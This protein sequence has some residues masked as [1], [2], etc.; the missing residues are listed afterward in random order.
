MRA[1]DP[2]VAVARA[3]RRLGRHPGAS[4][5]GRSVRPGLAVGAALVAVAGLSAA[6]TTGVVVPASPPP[7]TVA[8]PQGSQVGTGTVPVTCAVPFLGNMTFI[9]KGTGAVGTV[10][11]PGQQ[12]YL[13]DVTGDLEVPGY[14]FTLASIVGAKTVNASVTTLDIDASGATPSVLNAAA[15]PIQVDGI[16]VVAGESQIV[17]APTSGTLT[18]GPFTAPQSG[19]LSLSI[20]AVSVTITLITASGGTTFIPLTV[21]CQAPSPPIVLVGF[22]VDPNAPSSPPVEIA[23]VDAPPFN[24]PVGNVE[25]SLNVPLSCTVSG[26]GSAQLDGTITGEL[27]AVLPTGLPYTIQSATGSLGIPA[28]VVSQL[29]QAY[30]TATSA[31]GSISTLD[32]DATNSTPSVLNVASTPIDVPSQPLA[33]GQGL[34]IDLP[35]SGTL[36]VGPFTAGSVG[37]TTLTWGQSAGTLTLQSASGAT[38]ATADVSC[39]APAGPV[40]ILYE[41]VTPG[42]VPTITAVSPDSGPVTGGTSVTITGTGF[43]GAQGVSVGDGQASFVVNSSTQ[44]TATIP[45]GLAPGAAAITVLGTEGP[46]Q[47]SSVA[48]FTYTSSSS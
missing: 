39:Q 4:G 24:V 46:S 31:S 45:P 1:M 18:L 37:D 11:G 5:D 20:G 32:I 40:V 30:P 7:S 10:I 12:F 48:Q 21:S 26:V 47:P 23:D 38:V 36:S 44:I 27:P 13:T 16:P 8:I 14:F 29:M 17:D 42:P 33:Q 22:Q 9:A 34:T 28:S 43:T 3:L 2:V 41:P 35:A 25:G 19:P 6:C 15:T